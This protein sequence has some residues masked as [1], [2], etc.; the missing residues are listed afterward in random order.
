M[1]HANTNI[2]LAIDALLNALVLSSEYRANDKL[3]KSLIGPWLDKAGQQIGY[4]RIEL[5]QEHEE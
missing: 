3:D 1:N 4:A 2:K 5:V